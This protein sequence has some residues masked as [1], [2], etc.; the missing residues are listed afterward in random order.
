MSAIFRQSSKKDKEWGSLK[1]WLLLP[2]RPRRPILPNRARCGVW[3]AGICSICSP[4]SPSSG[5]ARLR[6][7]TVPRAA[8]KKKKTKT[9]R[10]KKKGLIRLLNL[11]CPSDSHWGDPGPVFRVYSVAFPRPLK[12]VTQVGRG[13]LWIGIG[14]R[15]KNLA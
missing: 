10:G 5:C 12:H 7:G 1:W 9:K 4:S 13:A 2:N 3:L 11:E 6:E 14:M 8:K 15:S